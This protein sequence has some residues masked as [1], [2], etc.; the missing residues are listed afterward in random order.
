MVH[1]TALPTG[2]T[3]AAEIA[4]KATAEQRLCC[5]GRD[6]PC[7]ETKWRHLHHGGVHLMYNVWMTI[8]KR[9]QR[10]K[11]CNSN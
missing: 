10:N 4:P 9:W 6:S 1:M 11:Q 3:M 8:P 7:L 5:R 2:T